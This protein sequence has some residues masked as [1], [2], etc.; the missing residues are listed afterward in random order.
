MTRALWIAA[1]VFAVIA[2]AAFVLL[3]RELFVIAGIL[4]ALAFLAWGFRAYP[5]VDP[6]EWAADEWWHE[7]EEVNA[8][9]P[10]EHDEWRRAVNDMSEAERAAAVDAPRRALG[11]IGDRDDARDEIGGRR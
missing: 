11:V 6:D 3:W 4:C 10:H 8:M 5:D 9:Y 2:W 1:W 7:P